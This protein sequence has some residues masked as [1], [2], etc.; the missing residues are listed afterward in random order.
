MEGEKVVNLKLDD[1]VLQ[2]VVKELSA[3]ALSI[4]YDWSESVSVVQ[5][6]KQF[7]PPSLDSSDS[8][9]TVTPSEIF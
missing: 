3:G 7:E 1:D 5:S 2:D 8:Q 9:D 6:P 4:K